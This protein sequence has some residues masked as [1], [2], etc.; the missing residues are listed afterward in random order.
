MLLREKHPEAVIHSPGAL[1]G[2]ARC[3][4]SKQSACIRVH[5]RLAEAPQLQLRFAA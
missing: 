2:A 3:P 5:L 1:G 4:R